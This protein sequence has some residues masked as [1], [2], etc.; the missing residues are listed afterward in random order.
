MVGGPAGRMMRQRAAHILANMESSGCWRW[1]G[2]SFPSLWFQQR[3]VVHCC[4]ERTHLYSLLSTPRQPL[5]DG[6][7]RVLAAAAHPAEQPSTARRLAGIPGLLSFSVLLRDSPTFPEI[8]SGTSQGMQG[9][10]AGGGVCSWLILLLRS[11]STAS[12]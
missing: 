2:P 4:E 5:R 3:L 12:P 11:D 1:V 9:T 6:R 7:Q 8:L 10:G